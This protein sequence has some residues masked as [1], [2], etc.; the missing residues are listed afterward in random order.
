LNTGPPRP[1]G[2]KLKF[3]G[4]NSMTLPDARMT[5]P[6][7]V[8]PDVVGLRKIKLALLG[9]DAKL[10]RLHHGAILSPEYV[11]LVVVAHSV[12]FWCSSRKCATN[13]RHI[14]DRPYFFRIPVSVFP[15]LLTALLAV[16]VLTA[17]DVEE[18][19][20]GVL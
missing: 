2:G 12:I 1:E 5:G 16:G 18:P 8:D 14:G 17:A 19:E 13:L 3:I 9:R 20:L 6:Q 15:R 11:L 4:T 10:G 7:I